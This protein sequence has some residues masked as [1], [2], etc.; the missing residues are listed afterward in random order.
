MEKL[1]LTKKVMK[2]VLETLDKG[3]QGIVLVIDDNGKLYIQQMA[4]SSF[5]TDD[6]N[7]PKTLF[8]KAIVSMQV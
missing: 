6:T 4:R 5:L 1:S 2:D 7:S 3:A 8:K